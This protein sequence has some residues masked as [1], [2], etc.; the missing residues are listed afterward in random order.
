MTALLGMLA[1]AGYQN[2]DK[3][4]E[5]LSG[6]GNQQTA[7]P[8]GMQASVPQTGGMG[9]AM[10][11]GMGGGMGQQAGGLLGGG[12]LG[13]LGGLMSHLGLGGSTA[14][15][16]GSIVNGGIGDLL[17][18]FRENGQGDVAQSWVND[19]PNREIS[20]ASL[21]SALGPDVLN[22]L[23]QHTGLTQDELLTRLSATLPGA[24]DRY[25]PDGRVPTN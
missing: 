3:I 4:G 9:S 23:S 17:N 18:R 19:G 21:Q 2:R 1:V 6:L 22:T 14:A 16:S 7:Q 24:I 11:G 12:L 20:A 5:M 10:G 25:T 15:N 13:G 8:S